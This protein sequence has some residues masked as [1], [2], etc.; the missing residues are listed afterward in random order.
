MAAYKMRRDECWVMNVGRSLLS[1]SVCGGS[2]C[3][4]DAFKLDNHLVG[5][6]SHRPI[7]YDRAAKILSSVFRMDQWRLLESSMRYNDFN[8]EQAWAAEFSN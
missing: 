8:R 6:R 4:A 5:A 1:E 7:E 2:Y 3:R